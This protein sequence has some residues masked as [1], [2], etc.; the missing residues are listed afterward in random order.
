MPG[1]R[2]KPT[3]PPGSAP[4]KRRSFRR[5]YDE[6]EA[7]RAELCARLRTL[8]HRAE[9]HPAYKGAL[10]LLNNVYRREKLA[11]RLT[12]L[13]SAAWLIDILEKLVG[14]M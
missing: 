2:T 3:T 6:L 8:G 9:A 4:P 7:R 13:Q 11:R 1:R 14:T 5:Q 12:V 10:K